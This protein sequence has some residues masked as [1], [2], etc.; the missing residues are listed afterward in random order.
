MVLFLIEQPVGKYPQA[1]KDL[2]KLGNP[3]DAKAKTIH[4]SALLLVTHK[5]DDSDRMEESD[6]GNCPQGLF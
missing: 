1:E 4:F 6:D 2:F 5:G 3:L